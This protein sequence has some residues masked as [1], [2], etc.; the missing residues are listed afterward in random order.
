MCGG[1]LISPSL[2]LSA[3][4]CDGAAPY[5]RVGAYEDKKDGDSVSIRSTIIHP[6]YDKS[7]L[8]M[9]IMIYELAEKTD[10]PYIKLLDKKIKNGKFT[11][12]GFGDTDKGSDLE[13]AE[14]LQEVEL[15]YVDNYYCD[16]GHGGNKEV[17]ED[18]LCVQG[19]NKDSC[20]GKYTSQN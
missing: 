17:T 3:A 12:L 2:V 15:S 6:D 16:K 4:H 9:D 20:I 1:V 14:S 19:N 13:L 10:Y 18:M 11:V 5:F 7:E 8:Y